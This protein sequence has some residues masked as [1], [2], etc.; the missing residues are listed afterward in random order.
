M[1][2]VLPN[3]KSFIFNAGNKNKPVRELGNVTQK[4]QNAILAVFDMFF[5]CKCND[6][7]KEQIKNLEDMGTKMEAHVKILWNLKQAIMYEKPRGVNMRKLHSQ[8]HIGQHIRMFGSIIF[9]DT[10]DFESAHKFLTTGIWRRTS[11]KLCSLTHEL[12]LAS[13]A[14]SFSGHLEFYAILKEDG[15]TQCS[16][17][18]GPKTAGDDITINPFTKVKDIRFVITSETKKDGSHILKGC[19]KNR[20]F[21]TESLFN[22]NSLPSSNH[23]SNYLQR[24]FSQDQE[25]WNEITRENSLVEF[26]IV[27]AASYEGSKDSDVGKGVIY[28]ML[29]NEKKSKL[30]HDFVTVN[31]IYKDSQGVDTEGYQVAQ[32]LQMIQKHT[33][34]ITDNKRVLDSTEWFFIIQYLDSIFVNDKTSKPHTS[35]EYI[36]VLEW[37][38]KVNSENISEFVIDMISL[39]TI[40]GN[41]M[42]IPYFSFIGKG[43]NGKKIKKPING[44]PSFRDIFWYVDRKFFDRSGWEQLEVVNDNMNQEILNDVQSFI[45]NNSIDL[46]EP[47][48]SELSEELYYHIYGEV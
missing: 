34:V 45:N 42:V 30:R 26:S 18:F 3:Q 22:H 12:H 2:D 31:C 11:K 32:V 15:V 37:E 13:V 48:L 10:A 33:Y 41:A 47:D 5:A 36:S 19:G 23:L 44:K 21:F 25:L 14:Q 29:T 28:A 9:A 1:G 35:H 38:K 8:N 16:E 4:V 20:L 17:K 7:T 39:D 40:V 43:K 27:G 24:Y 6:F 46:G